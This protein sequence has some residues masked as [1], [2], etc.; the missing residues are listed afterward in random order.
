MDYSRTTGATT[1]RLLPT[2]NLRDRLPVPELGQDVEVSVVDVAKATCFFRAEEIGLKRSE[3]HTSE[4]QSLIR[5][6]YAVFC[7][8]KTKNQQERP[9][10]KFQS[11]APHI[12][13]NTT[14]THDR[15][16]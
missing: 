4:L 13:R 6:S 7:L 10:S 16:R 11:T 12:H 15:Y 8:K 2:G 14:L 9:L 5:T 3:E 1:G